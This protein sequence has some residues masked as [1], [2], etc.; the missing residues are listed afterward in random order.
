[1]DVTPYM[2]ST[3][4]KVEDIR[5]GPR[6]VRIKDCR[7]GQFEK[8]DLH[9][10]DGDKLSLNATNVKILARA[11]G[12]DSRGWVGQTIELFIGKTEYRGEEQDS[13]LVRPVSPPIAAEKRGSP[14]PSSGPASSSRELDDEIPF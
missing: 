9:L 3:F 2:G 11:Y 6:Q 10:E 5:S 7:L 13:V 4:L 8:L 1:M 14:E 12:R